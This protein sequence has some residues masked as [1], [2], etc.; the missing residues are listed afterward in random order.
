[1]A[2]SYRKEKN[3]IIISLDCV[4]GDYRLDINSGIFYGVKGTPIKT[5]PH[6]SMVTDLFPY[7]GRPRNNT[8]LE[9]VIGSMLAHNN[10]TP[11]FRNYVQ[12][13]QAADRI[14]AIGYPCLHID[15]DNLLFIAE[16]LKLFAKW[17]EEHP[18]VDHF[19]FYDFKQWC[20]FEQIRNT[21]GS[22]AS[23]L[24]PEMVSAIEDSGLDL[25]IEEWGVCA[26]YLCRGKMWEYTNGRVNKLFEY[27]RICRMLEKAPDKVNNFMRE[28]CETK[29]VYELRKAEFDDKQLR[30]NYAKHSKA[31]EFAYGDYVVSIPSCGQD[32]VTEG[33]EM[34]HCVGSY[35]E[36]VVEGRTYICFVRHKNT[37]NECYIT[38]QVNIDGRIGQYFLAYDRY[39]H[40]EADHAFKEAFAN[41]L[42]EVWGE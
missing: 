18:V 17:N 2:N 23:T 36:K 31:W 10:G 25:S 32:I 4:N 35:V 24:T 15:N 41:H 37:P 33:R 3:L 38:C 27:I 30:A 19:R 29:R 16:N 21:L 39:I 8:N 28:Y 22:L 42:R 26:Y 12:L 13:M 6:K 9:K 34:H 11:N 7:W 5:V 40:T 20:Q 14:D 1:M